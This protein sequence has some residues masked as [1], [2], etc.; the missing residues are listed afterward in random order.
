MQSPNAEGKDLH[1]KEEIPL[2]NLDLEDHNGGV[3]P[4]GFCSITQ[5]KL[6][7]VKLALQKK[8]LNAISMLVFVEMLFSSLT[9]LH[10]EAL[11]ERM[12]PIPF[13]G[14]GC[15]FCFY[16]FENSIYFNRFLT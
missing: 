3:L 15:L 13:G 6:F 1:I 12:Q 16:M 4:S 8:V 2:S 7:V 10:F 9:K 11:V 5:S 14:V